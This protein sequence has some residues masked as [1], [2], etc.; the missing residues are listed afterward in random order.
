MGSLEK[1]RDAA[2]MS[3]DGIGTA[4]EQVELNLARDAKN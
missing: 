4:E 2:Q 3:R 1:Y